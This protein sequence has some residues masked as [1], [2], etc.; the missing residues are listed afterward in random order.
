MWNIQ[1]ITSV[2]TLSSV[3]LGDKKVIR[4]MILAPA[5][6]G[7]ND[8]KAATRVDKTNFDERWLRNLW[9]PKAP[10]QM[11]FQSTSFQTV[12]FNNNPVKTSLITIALLIDLATPLMYLWEAETYTQCHA[13][14]FRESW[15]LFFPTL[16]R[17]QWTAVLIMTD[18]YS[19]SLPSHRCRD[20]FCDS[21]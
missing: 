2:W 4:Q 3:Q 13:F 10:K 18:V 5:S 11:P 12:E 17:N 21:R 7:A 8:I 14:L 6:I 9:S 19:N 16:N 20:I 15:F 1:C